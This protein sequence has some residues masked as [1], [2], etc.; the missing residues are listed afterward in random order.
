MKILTRTSG[1]FLITFLTMFSCRKAYDPPVIRSNNHFLAVDGFIYTGNNAVST[2]MLSRSVNLHEFGQKIPELNAAV[3]IQSSAGE[4]YDLIDSAGNGIYQSGLLNLDS[5]RQYRLAINTS[6]GNKFLSDFVAGKL[7]P[8]IDSLSWELVGDPDTVDQM[9]AV[10]IYV[11]AHDPTNATR[12]YRWDYLQ[13]FKHVSRFQSSWGD[14]GG[15]V[16]PYPVGYDVHSCWST[17]RSQNIALGTSISLT[18]D[19]ISHIPIAHFQQDDPT[20]DIGSSFLVRQYPLTQE[21]YT[22]WLTI[23][24]NSQSLGGLFDLQPSQINGNLHCITNSSIQ[25]LGYISAS[26]VQEKRIY[27]S[28]KSLLGWQSQHFDSTTACRIDNILVDPLNTLVYYYPDTAYGPYF[29]YGST[30][31][32][33][34]KKCLD[35]RYQGGTNAKPAFWPQYD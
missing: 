4:I 15:F 2:I 1:Y 10:N 19:V 3:T 16:Y 28:N 21:G 29:F 18:Q 26:T 34:P 20:L 24:K 22:Y 33:A 11:N 8:P 35:C 9:Q 32:V 12:Y 6:D 14:S 23:Q 7:A 31:F 30:L 5:T 25:V 13:T 17:V 27:I